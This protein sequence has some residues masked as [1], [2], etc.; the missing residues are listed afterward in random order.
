MALKA[1]GGSCIPQSLVPAL[2]D[3][4]FLFEIPGLLNLAPWFGL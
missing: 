3:G 2:I 1:A 4:K